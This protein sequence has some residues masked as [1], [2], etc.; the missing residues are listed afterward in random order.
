MMKSGGSTNN[1]NIHEHDHHIDSKWELLP[2][3]YENGNNNHSHV[4][5]KAKDRD[6]DA[7][8]RLHLHEFRI[9]VPSQYDD[10]RPGCVRRLCPSST[11]V[12]L[13]SHCF[14]FSYLRTFYCFTTV[15][16]FICSFILIY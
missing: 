9:A 15:H 12:Y 11:L 1:T 8:W 3:E 2:R 5:V 14:G 6:R 13:F 7:S 4:M 16:F 10:R